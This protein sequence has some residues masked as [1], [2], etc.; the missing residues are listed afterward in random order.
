MFG[1]SYDVLAGRNS[2]DIINA[3]YVGSSGIDACIY[4]SM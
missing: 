2:L 1:P 3:I 4:G